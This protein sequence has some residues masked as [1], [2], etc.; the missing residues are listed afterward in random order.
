MIH[1]KKKKEF[2]YDNL[3]KNLY[4]LKFLNNFFKKEIR[5]HIQNLIEFKDFALEVFLKKKVLK[6]NF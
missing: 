3:F 2:K 4:I 6:N 1:Y 5:K